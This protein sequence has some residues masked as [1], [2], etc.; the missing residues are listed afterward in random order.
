MQGGGV[1]QWI[2]VGMAVGVGVILLGVLAIVLS[3]FKDATTDAN[4]TSVI[5]SGLT[6]LEN[7]SSQFGTIGTIAGVLLLFGLVVASGLG[8]YYLYQRVR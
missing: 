6:F 4:A 5:N 1:N 7:F 3:A 8:G 2:G